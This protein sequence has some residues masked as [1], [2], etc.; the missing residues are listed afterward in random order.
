MHQLLRLFVLLA[1]L[2]S[3]APDKKPV[4]LDEANL[5]RVLAAYYHPGI[6]TSDAAA[7]Y[8]LL[9]AQSRE[10][11][12]Q[13]DWE[14]IVSAQTSNVT[15]V[16]V[17]KRP[18]VKG[19]TYAVV[20]LSET[21][22]GAS[23]TSTATW[24]M[25]KNKWRRIKLPLSMDLVNKA[26]MKND[27][28]AAKA[29]AGKWLALDPF[30]TQAVETLIFCA[31][32]SEAVDPDVQDKE[33][34][35]LVNRLLSINPNDTRALFVAVSYANDVASGRPYLK[36]LEGTSVYRQ[37]VDA[38]A[39]KA[40]QPA[41]GKA[42]RPADDTALLLQKLIIL[43][44]RNKITE[45]RKLGLDGRTNDRL[46]KYLSDIHPEDAAEF[47]GRLGLAYNKAGANN[48]ALQWFEFGKLRNPHNKR[49][50]ELEV[51]LTEDKG[52]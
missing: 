38:L 24:V 11:I 19:V 42:A 44:E 28:D 39:G 25:E 4:P 40:R 32:R 51:L 52:W 17:V 29:A 49:I 16:T 5:E 21:A 1:V 10:Q 6:G 22:N 31:D 14:A 36:R 20:S 18:V 15:S 45:F 37:A 35:S 30:S 43:A 2:I 48:F 8:G 46:I 26:F 33:I 7:M 9:S 41:D 47:A 34:A 13:K 27:A 23:S 12:P 3:C 50:Q